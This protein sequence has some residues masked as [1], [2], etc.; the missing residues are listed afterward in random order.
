MS[1]CSSKLSTWYWL[2]LYEVLCY[3]CFMFLSRLSQIL[4]KVWFDTDTVH[5]DTISLCFI[6]KGTESGATG[7]CC[8]CLKMFQLSSNRLL[9][10]S[11]SSTLNLN[12]HFSLTFVEELQLSKPHCECE[13]WS[14]VRHYHCLDLEYISTAAGLAGLLKGDKA[15][16]PLIA[17]KGGKIWIY[18]L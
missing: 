5:C 13:P 12:H 6:R 1:W 3:K 10:L 7:L 2:Q 14:L 4:V 16:L 9:H 18:I 17:Q 8:T 11:R 15:N